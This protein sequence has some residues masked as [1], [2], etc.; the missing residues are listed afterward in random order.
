M[1]MVADE[2]FQARLRGSAEPEEGGV[3]EPDPVRPVRA[4][5]PQGTPQNKRTPLHRPSRLRRIRRGT[6]CRRSPHLLEEPELRRYSSPSSSLPRV[7]GERGTRKNRNL[8]DDFVDF[9]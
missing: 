9:D 8:A 4:D 2:E 7:Q 3:R 5:P 6:I 1:R